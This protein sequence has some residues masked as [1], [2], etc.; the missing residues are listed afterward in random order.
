MRIDWLEEL[1]AHS[2]KLN[3]RIAGFDELRGLRK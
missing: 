1:L 3:L 2:K